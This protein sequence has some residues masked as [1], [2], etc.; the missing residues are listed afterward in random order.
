MIISNNSNFSG[1][2]W[3]PYTT[4][5]VWDLS[6]G[7]STKTVYVKFR[8]YA[9]F[10]SDTVS[11]SIELPLLPESGISSPWLRLPLTLNGF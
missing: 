9:H 6:A 7:N 5:K 4:S 11:A 8:D 10:E 2:S 1:A 3:E